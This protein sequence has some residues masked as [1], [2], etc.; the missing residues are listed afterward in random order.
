M[1]AS[2]FF[3]ILKAG[4]ESERKRLAMFYAELCDIAAIP[5]CNADYHKGLKQNYTDALLGAKYDKRGRRVMDA[6]DPNT[7]QTL[8]SILGQ[9][10]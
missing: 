4:R 5:L 1:P 8:A 6:K 2:R 10:L 7:A 3:A 9:K